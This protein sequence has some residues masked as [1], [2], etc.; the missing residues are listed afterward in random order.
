MKV[1]D[2][3]YKSIILIGM[4]SENEPRILPMRMTVTI[5]QKKIRELARVTEN[6]IFTNHAIERMEERDITDFEV[7]D[8][9]RTGYANTIQDSKVGEGFECKITKKL[10]GRREAGVVTAVKEKSR[11]LVIITVEWE[12]L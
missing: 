9:L 11:K 8:I 6:I 1:V 12:D 2:L 4:K 5:A 7:Y 3:I 10:Q